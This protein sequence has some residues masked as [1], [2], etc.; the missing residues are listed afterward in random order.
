MVHPSLVRTLTT[1]LLPKDVATIHT[2][3]TTAFRESVQCVDFLALTTSIVLDL[4]IKSTGTGHVNVSWL[5]R[6][7]VL[8]DDVDPAIRTA[9]RAR[10]LCLSCL[11]THYAD[12]WEEVCNTPPARRPLPHP[13]RRLQRRRMDKPRPAPA[14]HLL[15]RPNANM[16]PP[17]RPPNRLRPPPSPRRDRR[18]SRHGLGPHPGRTPHHLPAS[19]SPSCANTKPTPTTTPPAA[20][21]SPP[22]KA[23]PA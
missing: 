1:A 2:N 21:S 12:L 7:P 8:A 18:S 3:L 22:P 19:S 6:L 11:T 17:R 15:P 10:A 5:S 13:H 4:F 9:L 16:E 23:S 20:S 14:S